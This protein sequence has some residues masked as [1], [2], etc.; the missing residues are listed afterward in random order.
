MELENDL[1]STFHGY[2]VEYAE[3][4][5]PPSHAHEVF[6][7]AK[8][9]AIKTKD[10]LIPYTPSDVLAFEKQMLA[11]MH[12]LDHSAY[13]QGLFDEPF[14]M[15]GPSVRFPDVQKIPIGNMVVVQTSITPLDDEQRAMGVTCQGLFG[16]LTVRYE[17]VVLPDEPKYL[18]PI[19]AYQ[20]KIGDL[21][22]PHFAGSVYAYGDVID[23]QIE[24]MIDSQNSKVAECLAVL[25][26]HDDIIVVKRINAL[27]LLLTSNSDN[28][29]DFIRKVGHHTEV[30]VN[31]VDNNDRAYIHALLDLIG[32]YIQWNEIRD[33]KTPILYKRIASSDTPV[34][35][36]ERYRSSG[37]FK[38]IGTFDTVIDMP[39]FTRISG[40][41]TPTEK[42]GLYIAQ[43]K[44]QTTRYIKLTDIQSFDI[45]GQ[46]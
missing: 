3:Q 13:E 39:I 36:L 31:K 32:S 34:G 17:E 14:T 5:L 1:P 18:R 45:T 9:L 8:D 4:M 15:S 46:N 12:V 16:G 11:E 10:I 20:S 44:D 41:L 19:L 7:R 6:E 38:C 43:I 35:N 22:T 24:F 30:I 2:D 25:L 27:N 40:V 28:D 23:T 26:Q 29:A 33:I 42:S 21:N 37:V